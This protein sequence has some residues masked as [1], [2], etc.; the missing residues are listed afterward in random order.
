MTTPLQ[1]GEM[2]FF[3]FLVGLIRKAMFLSFFLSLFW[4]TYSCDGRTDSTPSSLK[5]AQY[6]ERIDTCSLIVL[7]PKFSHIDLVCGEMPS[8]KDTSVILFAGACFTGKCE[9]VF[10]HRNI[11][12]NHVSKGVRYQGYRCNR[13]TGAF[14]YANGRWRFVYKNYEEA[15]NGM[16]GGNSAAFSQEMLIHGGKF[17]KTQRKDTNRNQFRALCQIG[18]KLCVIESAE[19]M[20]FGEFK[21]CLMKVNVREA[22]YL[23]MGAGWNYAWYRTSR[24]SVTELHRKTHNYGTNWITFYKK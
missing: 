21:K 7:Y 6:V 9:P 14:L 2:P 10:H 18:D 8:L 19:K 23:D 24:D 3:K 12:G 11:A 5:R 13:N 22:L 20:E 1:I 16:S 4:G 17:V 15:M